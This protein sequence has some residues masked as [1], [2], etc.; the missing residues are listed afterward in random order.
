MSSEAE[1]LL[2]YEEIKN[3][4]ESLKEDYNTIF[5]LANTSDEFAT[6]KVIKDQ[7]VAEERALKSIQAKLPA[8]ESFGAKY[9]VEIL[10][11]HEILF[12][13][14]PNV[15][16]IRVL[17][18]AQAI[19]SKLDKQNYVFPARYKVWLGMPSFTEGRP[20]ETRLAIDGC[21]EESQNRTLADQ[22]LFL[23]RKFEGGGVLMPTVED[24]AVAHA[25][26]FVVTRQNLFRGMKI[27]TLNGSLYYD[28]LG[29]GMDRFSL[30]W[31]RFVDVAVASYLPAETVEKLREEKKN[32]RNL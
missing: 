2:Q 23:R 28:S 17:E 7:I 16:R 32:A 19:F 24:L 1:I 18:E 30:E 15:P 9:Q 12:V 27:R 3:R 26:F 14:P 21:V 25:L 20:T 31:N 8:R 22:K 4:L 10:G 13:I 6:L 29:L 5:G 11:P